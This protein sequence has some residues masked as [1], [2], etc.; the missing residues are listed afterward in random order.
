V[1]DDYTRL[2]WDVRPHPR[3]GTIEVRMPDQPTAVERSGFFVALLQALVVAVLE[4][5]PRPFDP[6]A[7]AD[8]D[9]NRKAAARRGLEARLVHPDGDRSVDARELVEELLELVRPHA[10]AELV[11][12]AETEALR[13]LEVG[14]ADGLSAVCADLVDRSL[15][16]A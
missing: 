4:K 5:P 16:S 9:E 11:V 13:Q 15:A 8:Y 2:W 1:A 3:L 12:P 7:R 14:R 10:A 6:L